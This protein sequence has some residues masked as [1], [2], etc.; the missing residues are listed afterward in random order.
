MVTNVAHSQW[1]TETFLRPMIAGEGAG[2]GQGS[3][4]LGPGGSK[5]S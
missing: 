3:V 2:G 5:V 4:R 1:D